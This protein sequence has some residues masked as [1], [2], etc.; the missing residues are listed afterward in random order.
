MIS[1]LQIRTCPCKFSRKMN[2][3]KIEIGTDSEAGSHYCYRNR[4]RSLETGS[5]TVP[6]PVLIPPFEKWFRFHNGPG[7]QPT[8][9]H[10]N[11]QL[12]ALSFILLRQYLE[13]IRH[14][15]RYAIII[16]VFP[17]LLSLSLY[18]YIYIFSPI[19]TPIP[20]LGPVGLQIP[21]FFRGFKEKKRIKEQE[22][23]ICLQFQC[24]DGAFSSRTGS[25]LQ[26]QNFHFEYSG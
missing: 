26:L 21:F 6:V 1:L 10:P 25:D 19:Y 8:R 17:L 20:H 23:Y 11:S 24:V 12:L 4:L 5:N 15:S 18:I 9:L 14:R 13:T 22:L 16:H 2:K 7:P 3:I